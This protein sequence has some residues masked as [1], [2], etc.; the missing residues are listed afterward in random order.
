MLD[1]AKLLDSRSLELGEVGK[2]QEQLFVAQEQPK[3]ML[4]DLSDFSLGS[5][6]ARHGQ[7]PPSESRPSFPLE[8]DARVAVNRRT[9]D[10]PARTGRDRRC[11]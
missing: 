6:R 5:E 7:F 3:T 11:P 10:R 9:R 8:M 2:R 4:R 1:L